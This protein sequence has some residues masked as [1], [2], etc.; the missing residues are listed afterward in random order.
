MSQSP[1]ISSI[2]SNVFIREYLAS[3][4]NC[5]R[6]AILCSGTRSYYGRRRTDGAARWER[7]TGGLRRDLSTRQVSM[8]AIGGTIGTGLFLGTG[9]SLA[10]GGPA[11][12]LICYGIIGFIV[13]ITLLLL[14]ELSTQYP[15][16]GS[17]TVY[18]ARF[19]SP[20]YAFALSW[21]Y[22]F[23]DAVS[24]ASDLTAAQLVLQFWTDWHPWVISVVFLVFLLSVNALSVRSY[25]EMEYILS[26]LKV[27]TIIVF[28]IT[29]ALVNAG[30]NREHTPIRGRNWRIPGAPFVDGGAGFA[31]VFVTASF[32]Y[33]G[34]E[35][36]AITAGETKNPTKSMPRVVRVVFWR[37]LLFY[38][39]SILMIGLNVPYTYPNL[40]NRSTTTSPFTIV[41][42]EAGSNV[43][44]SF[45][46]TV[47]LSS[48]LSAGN[49]ALYAGTRILYSLSTSSPRLAP[50]FFSHT[51]SNGVPLR[52]LLGTAS[53]SAL[54]FASSFVGSG[55]LWGWLQNIVGVSNQIAWL[56]I[57]IASWRFRQA[58]I[59]QGRPLSE[60]KYRAGWTWPWGP[61]FVVITVSLVILFQGWTSFYPVFSPV[62]FVSLYLELPVMALMTLIWFI[63]RHRHEHEEDERDIEDD[64]R[65]A[66]R[67]KGGWGWIWRIWETVA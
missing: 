14:G 41:F 44:A 38:V 5:A 23:N 60:M 35:S 17:F 22:W 13:Y 26:S 10:Q 25:G 45:M 7:Y 4:R 59:A 12:I 1:S 54:C 65:R 58:W 32:A 43:A 49:H 62:D 37:I 57:G 16:A 20:S 50:G 46:N 30:V 39:L 34:T 2:L 48:V 24:V 29:G 64:V 19:F 9:R 63:V 6:K 52:A 36:L 61:P 42:R 67:R 55:V 56:S 31:R 51:T 40:S 21:N 53:I 47:I 3:R 15:V 11:S 27:V 8:I 18:A 28:I 33:G 66:A